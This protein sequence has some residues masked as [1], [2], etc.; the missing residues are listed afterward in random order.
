MMSISNKHEPGFVF[1][2][3]GLKKQKALLLFKK[4]ELLILRTHMLHYLLAF[5][6]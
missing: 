6:F 3:V 4:V 5:N 2:S 1:R